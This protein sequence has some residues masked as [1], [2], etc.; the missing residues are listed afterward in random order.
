MEQRPKAVSV[1]NAGGREPRV[2]CEQVFERIK[3][4]GLHGR[5]GRHYAWIFGRHEA[6]AVGI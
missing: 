1:A 2:R 4:T 6:Y 5:G 3:I